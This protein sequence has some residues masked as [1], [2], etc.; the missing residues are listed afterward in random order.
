LPA[1]Q[2]N[3]G[4]TLSRASLLARCPDF[5]TLNVPYYGH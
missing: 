5:D 2:W 1:A 4:G 3:G